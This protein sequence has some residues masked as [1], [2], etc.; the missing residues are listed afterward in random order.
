[1]KTLTCDVC[2]SIVPTP[3]MGRNFFHKAHRDICE[4]C[5]EKLELQMK[6]V[7]RTKIPFDYVWY[8]N[9]LQQSIEKAVQKGKFDVK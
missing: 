8:N 7:V 4:L 5:N 9:L 1:M 6:P 3:I 2:K